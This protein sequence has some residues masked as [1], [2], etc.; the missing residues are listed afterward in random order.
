M[1]S[2][3]P[4]EEGFIPVADVAIESVQMGATGFVLKGRGS[5]N[6]DYRLEMHLDMPVDRRT[7]TVL[8]EQLLAQ[9][10]WQVSRK[11]PEV[12]RSRL[13]AGRRSAR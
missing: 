5:D 7:R 1:A 12:F 8:G 13:K 9:S 10:E 3:N 11:S 2:P 6:S 4:P